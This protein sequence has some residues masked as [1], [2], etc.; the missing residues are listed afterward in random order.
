M[1]LKIKLDTDVAALF[2]A[3]VAVSLAFWEGIESREHNRK[4]V[5]PIL[6]PYINKSFIDEIGTLDIGVDSVGL[7]PVKV[8]H[9]SVF[10]NGRKEEVFEMPGYSTAY[11]SAINAVRGTVNNYNEDEGGK[12][13]LSI[14]DSDLTVGEVLSTNEHKVLLKLTSNLPREELRNAIAVVEKTLDVFICYCSVYD[15]QCS[16]V[17]IGENKNLSQAICLEPDT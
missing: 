5:V 6:N 1:K 15:D 14:D 7:G 2:V 3:F 12:A 11:N 10:F 8:S 17:H 9:F 4:S 13:F 16:M